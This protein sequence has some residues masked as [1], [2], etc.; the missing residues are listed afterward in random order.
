MRN[1]FFVLFV[2]AAAPLLCE[3][4]VSDKNAFIY[5]LNIE[6]SLSATF[7]EL[8]DDHFHSGLDLKT[9]G[10][11]GKEVRSAAEGYIYRIS[12]SPSG[13]GNAFIS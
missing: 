2:L 11:T 13:Y 9:G 3:A 10:V 4:Q 6:P 5:P 12:I 1:C 8:R 7:G